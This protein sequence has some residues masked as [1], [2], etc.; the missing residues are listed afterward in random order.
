MRNKF[1][2]HEVLTNTTRGTIRQPTSENA[3]LSFIL[4]P[5]GAIWEGVIAGSSKFSAEEP[6]LAV[7]EERVCRFCLDD[8]YDDSEAGIL[9]TPCDCVGTQ[10][11]VHER[12]LRQWQS[13]K[14][15]EGQEEKAKRCNVCQAPYA[16]RLGRLSFRDHC[17]K[18]CTYALNAWLRASFTGG[19]LGGATGTLV[20]LTILNDALS[21]FFDWVAQL[22]GPI[23]STG[24]FWLLLST[25]L[26][27]ILAVQPV[28]AGAAYFVFSCSCIGAIFGSFIF[29]VGIPYFAVEA[30]PSHLS[31]VMTAL[32]AR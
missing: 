12:C 15:R 11:Y 14:L 31:A 7:S 16:I 26:I 2:V 13:L 24:F 23:E 30:S 8:E 19:V 3:L 18:A 4:Q 21:I 28:I 22:Q 17:H 10:K 25:C 5:P 29:A 27:P 32:A 1:G 9:I 6:T 20:G